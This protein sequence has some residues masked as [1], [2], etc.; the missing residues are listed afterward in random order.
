MKADKLNWFV[1]EPEVLQLLTFIK[2]KRVEVSIYMLNTKN[3]EKVY[4]I[5]ISYKIYFQFYWN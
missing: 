5:P 1:S 4:N 2:V 3:A